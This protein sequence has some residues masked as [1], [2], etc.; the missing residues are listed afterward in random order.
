MAWRLFQGESEQERAKT[1][2]GHTQKTQVS[3]SI[4]ERR[5]F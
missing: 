4:T 5:F 1:C 2:D 3:L